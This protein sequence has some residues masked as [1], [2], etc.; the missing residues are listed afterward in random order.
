MSDLGVTPE[1]FPMRKWIRLRLAAVRE[2]VRQQLPPAKQLLKETFESL[3]LP[4][5]PL[6]RRLL[7]GL[8]DNLLRKM[9]N[10]VQ[11]RLQVVQRPDGI[12]HHLPRVQTLNG[13]IR[14]I[15]V[16]TVERKPVVDHQ[17][18]ES[19]LQRVSRF[20]RAPLPQPGA[21]EDRLAG[22][23]VADPFVEDQAAAEVGDVVDLLQQEIR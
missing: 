2:Q 8:V 16:R 17:S 19:Q 12:V 1:L 9:H 10:L 6:R 23:R 3:L 7:V 15:P 13:R 21:E 18:Y 20:S 22:V 5:N 11:P 14:K 4:L